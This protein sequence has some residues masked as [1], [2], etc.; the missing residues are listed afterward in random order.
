MG[1]QRRSGASFACG[2]ALI[3]HGCDAEAANRAGDTALAIAERLGF[4]KIAGALTQWDPDAALAETARYLGIDP[5]AERHL[6][7]VA[8]EMCEDVLPDGW[9]ELEDAATGAAYYFN[10]YTQETSW[11]HPLYVSKNCRF[12]GILRT[13]L[14]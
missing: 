8:Q 7:W 3:E 12:C 10:L 2:N 1:R 11:A 9:M 5:R 6:L 4:D 13:F 14:C